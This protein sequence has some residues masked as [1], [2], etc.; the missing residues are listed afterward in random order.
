MHEVTVMRF[1]VGYGRG[2]A[3][4]EMPSVLWNPQV[5]YPLHKSLPLVPILRHI[6]Q[7]TPIHPIPLRSTVTLSSVLRLGLQRDLFP[8][9]FPTKTLNALLLFPR[10]AT[11]SAH[12][13]FVPR[14]TLPVSE[15]VQWKL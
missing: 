2:Q 6:S 7:S 13:I 9:G 15:L 14:Y 8:S 10:C 11:S 3:N 12:R 4:Q 5:H 1:S